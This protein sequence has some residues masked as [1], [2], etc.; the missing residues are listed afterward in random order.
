MHGSDFGEICCRDTCNSGSSAG[1][2][3]TSARDVLGF[4]LKRTRGPAFSMLGLRFQCYVGMALARGSF[5]N[6]ARVR[7]VDRI[8]N[9]CLARIDN[10]KNEM[11]MHMR[12]R[13]TRKCVGLFGHF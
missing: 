5:T 13:K 10:I 7:W 6:G 1:V 11:H 3:G 2:D 12:G 4:I 9:I 8:D